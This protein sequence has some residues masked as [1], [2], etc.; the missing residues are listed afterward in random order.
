[1][2]KIVLLFVCVSLCFGLF[3]CTHETEIQKTQTTTE[4][5]SEAVTEPVSKT[6]KTTAKTES[7]A[8]EAKQTSA[9]STKAAS[10]T[11][12][13][14]NSFKPTAATT[15]KAAS[16]SKPTSATITKRLTTTSEPKTSNAVS[17]SV[18]IECQ[19]IL[20]HMDDLK[21]G[22]EEYLGSNGIILAATSLEMKNGATVYDALK[23][24]CD[25]NSI[26]L[27]AVHSGYGIYIAGINYIDEKDCGRYSGWTYTVNGAYVGKSADKCVLKN[28][29]KIVFSYKCE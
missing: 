9:S 21:A 4:A 24:A 11:T 13:A 6:G 1:M 29:D 28:G 27:N 2:K 7:S 20:S 14:T 18:K 16:S 3:G 5:V 17:C 19:S 25:S 10:T 22:H 26:S 8:S 15:T 12:K 23:T